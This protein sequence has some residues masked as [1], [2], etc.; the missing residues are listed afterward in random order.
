MYDQMKQYLADT[1]YPNKDLVRFYYEN[2]E[3]V[4]DIVSYNK[5]GLILN[6]LK[7]YLG[8]SAF[9][10]SLN[11]YL[12]TNKFKSAEAQNLRTGF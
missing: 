11:L 2:R 12:T 6:M 5:G 4:F 3:E 8:D 9:F 7:N 1:A 10:K